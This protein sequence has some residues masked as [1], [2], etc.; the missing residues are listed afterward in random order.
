MLTGHPVP[1]ADCNGSVTVNSS[2]V[3]DTCTQDSWV[4]HAKQCGKLQLMCAD[5]AV[6]L[7]ERVC[8]G[9]QHTRM[10]GVRG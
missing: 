10:L 1:A 7:L 3:F 9:E 4:A 2:G 5:A 6:L 8:A